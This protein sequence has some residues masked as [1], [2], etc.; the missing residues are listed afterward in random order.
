[1]RRPLSGATAG[2]SV[3]NDDQVLLRRLAM[4]DDG[5]VTATLA[6]GRA[7]LAELAPKTQA[8]V[9]LAGLIAVPSAA[10]SFQSSV[11][12][13]IAAGAQDDEVIAVLVSMAPIVGTARVVAAAPDLAL[14]LGYDVDAAFG[15][16]LDSRT[17][18]QT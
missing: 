13:A 2:C 7:D 6:R 4:S 16:S 18:P 1:M 10:A 9:R 3:N 5:A 12:A 11:A 17:R 15:G 8:L 14:S